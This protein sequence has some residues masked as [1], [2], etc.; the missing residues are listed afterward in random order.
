MRHF[1]VHV[2][3][4]LFALSFAPLVSAVT[5]VTPAVGEP[6]ENDVSNPFTNIFTPSTWTWTRS[7]SSFVTLQALSPASLDLNLEEVTEA[8]QHVRRHGPRRR[9]VHP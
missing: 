1:Q 8:S 3:F 4:T 7:W 6:A 2:L 5:V 9:A